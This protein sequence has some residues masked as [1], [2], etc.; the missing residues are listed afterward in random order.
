MGKWTQ[1]DAGSQ[2]GR[3]FVVTGANSGIGYE[4][5][6]MLSDKGA[7][8]VMACR[9]AERAEAALNRLK[10]AVPNAQA[11]VMALDLADLESVRAFAAAFADRHSRLDGLINNAGLMAIPRQLTKQ[12]FEMQLGVNHLG[13]F[14]LTA[15][16]L[17]QLSA[18]EGSRIVNVS[19]EVHR[20]GKIRFD[21]L[22]GERRYSR[23][24]AYMQSKLANVLFTRR[25]NTE[26]S[27]KGRAI[28]AYAC[29]PGYA[30]TELQGRSKR[31][32]EDFFFTKITN[33]LV[34]QSAAMGALPTLRAAVDPSL[35]AGAYVGPA[36]YFGARGYPEVVAPSRAAQSD[37]DAERLW[38]V[39]A[40]LT[41]ESL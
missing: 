34:A 26:F 27:A 24:G 39:S 38:K 18:T 28:T 12:G 9:S 36:G 33:R 30:A 16:L 37:E 20:Q 14:A 41:Q 13:H 6:R 15:R 1:D 31:P 22:M 19:S 17:P 3:V 8:V 10:Q 23:W 7:S 2:E 21:D 40:E 35:A 4:V 5:A 32:F 11:E 25:L 29:H